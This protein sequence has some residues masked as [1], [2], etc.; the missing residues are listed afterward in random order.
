MYKTTK[1]ESGAPP[2]PPYCRRLGKFPRPRRR[3]RLAGMAG[4]RRLPAAIEVLHV[5]RQHGHGRFHGHRAGVG[6]AFDTH[7]A[8][9]TRARPAQQVEPRGPG[10][11]RGTG[12]CSR[13]A[14]RPGGTSGTRRA[15]RSAAPER[16]PHV[17]WSCTAPP[18]HRIPVRRPP[19]PRPGR[20]PPRP[21]P[22]PPAA[23]NPGSTGPRSSHARHPLEERCDPA[24]RSGR[25]AGR[26]PPGRRRRQGAIPPRTA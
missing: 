13:R 6:V 25:S 12:S 11:P 17:P 23:R 14:S 5:G 22:R 15:S 24:P 7:V 2:A 4:S 3:I 26:G 20:P 8:T 18:R 19:P 16:P 21:R 1:S 10:R 9:V